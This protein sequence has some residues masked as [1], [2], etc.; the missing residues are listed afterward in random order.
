M[1][2]ATINSYAVSIRQT[3]L[4]RQYFLD[5]Q[6]WLPSKTLPSFWKSIKRNNLNAKHRDLVY[7]DCEETI[8]ILILALSARISIIMVLLQSRF[9]G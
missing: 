5:N 8:K 7:Q 1:W 2:V 9:T 3:S 4:C 6:D